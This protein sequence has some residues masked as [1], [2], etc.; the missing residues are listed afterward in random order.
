MSNNFQ[1][2]PL[3]SGTTSLHVSTLHGH[4][5]IV[6]MLISSGATINARD[7]NGQT[8][9]HI[10]AQYGY[11]DIVRSLLDAGADGTIRDNDGHLPIDLARDHPRIIPNPN[12]N[13]IG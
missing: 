11:I 8:P 12:D 2:A 5:D 6:N 10:A 3:P 7:G 1:T 4:Y 9:L 13:S